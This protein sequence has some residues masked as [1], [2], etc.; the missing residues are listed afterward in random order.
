LVAKGYG[1]SDYPGQRGY[2]ISLSS[3]AWILDVAKRIEGSRIVLYG[4]ALWDNH[5]DVVAL[6]AVQSGG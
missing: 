3:P 5:H 1:Y 6:Q 2:G 4:E